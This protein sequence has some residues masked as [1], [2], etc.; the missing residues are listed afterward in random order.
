MADNVIYTVRSNQLHQPMLDIGSKTMMQTATT[1][2]TTAVAEMASWPRESFQLII[3]EICI[4]CVPARRHTHQRC[5][6]N[7]TLFR[8]III[9]QRFRICMMTLFFMSYKRKG[10][11]FLRLRLQFEKI[12][13]MCINWVAVA[14]PLPNG[15]TFELEP[16]WECGRR[17]ATNKRANMTISLYF[18]FTG[19]LNWLNSYISNVRDHWANANG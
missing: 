3:Y 4:K 8:L 12:C 11:V 15:K 17:Q 16:Y 18:T 14:L 1:T 13:A 10:K 2:P 6:S 7:N 9:Y 5:R 19:T